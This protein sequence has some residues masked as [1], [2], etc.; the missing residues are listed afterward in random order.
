[1]FGGKYRKIYYY[2]FS[3][4]YKKQ[5]TKIDKDGNDKIVDILY[6]IKFTMF[7][8]SSSLS[9]LVDNLSEGVHNDKCIHR[10]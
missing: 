9:N 3:T 5:I 10:L 4:N 7:S 6:K 2:F 8:M 1:M